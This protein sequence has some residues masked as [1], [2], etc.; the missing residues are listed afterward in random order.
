MTPSFVNATFTRPTKWK[1]IRPAKPGDEFR[2]EDGTA[3]KVEANRGNLYVAVPLH[4]TAPEILVCTDC[5][6]FDSLQL[7]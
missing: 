2:N 3:T 4:G 1:L 6:T 5:V 7:Q